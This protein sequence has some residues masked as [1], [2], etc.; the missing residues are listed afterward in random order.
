MNV[1]A[2]TRVSTDEQAEKGVS[3]IAQAAKCRQ[4]CELH[5]A[6]LVGYEADEGLSGKTLQR[7]GLTKMID[8]ALEVAAESDEP[9]VFLV[10]SLSRMSRSVK[11]T[12]ELIERLTKAGVEFVSIVE[13]FDTTTAMGRAFL[14]IVAVLAELEREQIVE[15]TLAAFAHKRE[16]GEA[17]GNAPYGFMKG[18]DGKLVA[19]PEEQDGLRIILDAIGGAE[20][21]SYAG[22][23]RK[24]N[25]AGIPNRSG[26]QWDRGVV[27]R[28]VRYYQGDNGQQV[29]EVTAA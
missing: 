5:D 27:R 12:I 24:L 10:Y 6:E 2:Y 9:T 4:W 21:V 11:D 1:I 8:L 16:K 28:I 13:N 7:P 3:L 15:R 19:N 26:G 29:L 22:I 18:A 25:A 14:K 23:A 20:Q 17:L